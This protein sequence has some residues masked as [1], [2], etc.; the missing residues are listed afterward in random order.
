MNIT[1]IARPGTR[2][3]KT[4][5][6]EVVNRFKLIRA[7]N[8]GSITASLVLDDARDERSPLH[9]YFEWDDSKAAEKWRLEQARKL[10][11]QHYVIV[12]MPGQEATA[13]VRAQVIIEEEDGERGYR[14]VVAV[15]KNEEFSDQVLDRARE[16][17]RMWIARY[18]NF[19]ELKG[20]VDEAR[21][22]LKKLTV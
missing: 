19:T 9:K 4:A 10:I 6:R 11:Q 3:S 1:D 20:A 16:E 7:Q 5:I 21:G 22:L 14:S 12:T 2:W 15:M 8:G 17:M 13:P 18:E